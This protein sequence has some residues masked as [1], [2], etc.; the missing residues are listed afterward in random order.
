MSNSTLYQS[1]HPLKQAGIVISLSIVVMIGGFIIKQTGII[2]MG[3]RF[4]WLTAASFMLF[5]A[6]FNSVFSLMADDMNR[7]WGKSMLSF[8]GLAL[9]SGILAWLFSSIPIYNA[10]SYSWIFIV[11]GFGYLVFLSIMRMAKFIVEFAEKEEWN[12]PKRRK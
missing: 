1:L 5:F 3:D 6:V 4:A 8:A 12:A 7:Y 11:V 9:I 2:D 10:G